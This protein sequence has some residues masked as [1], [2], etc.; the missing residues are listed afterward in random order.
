MKKN[1]TSLWQTSKTIRNS[2]FKRRTPNHLQHFVYLFGQLLRRP[3]VGTLWV[4]YPE[5]LSGS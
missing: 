3:R 5:K 4:N 2:A 1:G